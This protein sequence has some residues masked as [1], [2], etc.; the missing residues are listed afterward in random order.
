MF[1]QLPASLRG[2]IDL[3]S[4]L[5]PGIDDGCRS[6]EES[7]ACIR[8]L[9]EVGFKASVCTPHFGREIY[10]E[11]TPTAIAEGVG[12][13]SDRVKA[14]GIDYQL[15][16]G[17]EIRLAKGTIA[18]LRE[19]GVP[20]LGNSRAVLVDYWGMFWP[21]YANDIFEWLL[22]EGYT[23]ILAHPER[24]EFTFDVLET[25]LVR[26]VEWGVLLQ[27]N[28]NS[29]VGH[30]GPAAMHLARDYLS[31]ERYWVLASDTHNPL[32]LETRL[33]GLADA[34]GRIEG[35]QLQ[36]LI[37]ERPAELLGLAGG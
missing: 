27:G 32:G 20:T 33:K 2:A 16:A 36:R 5:L 35:A 21:P 26:L 6:Y 29:F 13:L 18:W 22:G 7:L 9:S 19:V 4:H 28:L 12:R 15:L 30:E 10:P 17:A 3:H 25:H 8:R 14:A 11:N 34:A 37:V 31:Q 24:M 1:S 23:V